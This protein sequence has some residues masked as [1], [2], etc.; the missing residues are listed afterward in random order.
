MDRLSQ[1]QL[2]GGASMTFVDDR[3][4]LIDRFSTATTVNLDEKAR[5][6]NLSQFGEIERHYAELA[7]LASREPREAVLRSWAALSDLAYS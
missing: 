2:P 5:Q 3:V 1:I 6:A 4:K 7:V